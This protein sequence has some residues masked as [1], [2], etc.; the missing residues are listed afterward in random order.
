MCS[1]QT[2]QDLA[3]ILQAMRHA[4][5]A[6]G[7]PLASLRQGRLRRIAQLIGENQHTLANAI[8]ADG[9]AGLAPEASLA[10]TVTLL[11]QAAQNLPAVTTQA[12]VV[13]IVATDRLHL[14]LASLGQA[15]GAGHVAMLKLSGQ[16]PNTSDAL[17]ELSADYF[18]PHEVAVVLGDAAMDA[19]FAALPFDQ[20]VRA[21]AASLDT[22]GDST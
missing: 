9:G 14:A 2:A 7:P 4:L 21:D 3:T 6:D 8:R 19:V 10:A 13:G 11:T 20:L 16:T 22:I 12:G 18:G 17:V 5:L 15:F 1:P